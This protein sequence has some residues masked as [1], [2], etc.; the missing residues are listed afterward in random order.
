MSKIKAKDLLKLGFK[1]SQ[2]SLLS[3]DL[4][5]VIN[6]FCYIRIRI[7]LYGSGLRIEP[8]FLY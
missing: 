5:S 7:I 4:F 2:I 3:W 6:S 1:R 8:N